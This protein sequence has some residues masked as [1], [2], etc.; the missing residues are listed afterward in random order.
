MSYRLLAQA[1]LYNILSGLRDVAEGTTEQKGRVSL[2]QEVNVQ[3]RAG[4]TV[5]QYEEDTTEDFDTETTNAAENGI[6]TRGVVFARDDMKRRL[7]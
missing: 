4:T 3:W 5:D 2:P 6:G 7:V 1:W